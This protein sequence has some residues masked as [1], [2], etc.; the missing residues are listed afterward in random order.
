MIAIRSHQFKSVYIAFVIG[1]LLDV[2]TTLIGF[3]IIPGMVELN[4]IAQN[5]A[6]LVSA[7]IV[8]VI[9]A[10][11]I[12]ERV[13]VWPKLVWIAPA[14]VYLVVAWNVLNIVTSL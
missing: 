12:L 7:K 4:P 1:H 3:A 5:I 13:R 8:A 6:L 11:Y 14:L 9:L 2:A 10:V